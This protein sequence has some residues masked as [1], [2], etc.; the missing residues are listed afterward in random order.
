MRYNDVVTKNFMII[1]NF[2][3][4]NAKRSSKIRLYLAISFNDNIL[5]QPHCY[6]TGINLILSNTNAVKRR[7]INEKYE[8]YYF[9]NDNYMSDR[10]IEMSENLEKKRLYSYYT[11]FLL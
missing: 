8:N 5:D 4:E 3:K 7:K 1:L 6:L 2:F 10:E 11:Y 9:W